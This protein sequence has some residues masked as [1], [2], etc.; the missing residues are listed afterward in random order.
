[1][2]T[3]VIFLVDSEALEGKKDVSSH[4]WWK[5]QSYLKVNYLFLFPVV[6]GGVACTLWREAAFYWGQMAHPLDF[7][8]SKAWA[9]THLIEKWGREPDHASGPEDFSLVLASQDEKEHPW[10][11]PQG[12]KRQV[13]PKENGDQGSSFCG[14]YNHISFSEHC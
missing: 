2:F 11:K 9:L 5:G 1:M 13:S 12:E 10:V 6:L 4:F 14:G 8:F 3:H 7:Y